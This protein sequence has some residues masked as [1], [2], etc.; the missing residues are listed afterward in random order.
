MAIV[1]WPSWPSISQPFN[2]VSKPS[3]KARLF[4]IAFIAVN[5][6][7]HIF[8]GS[9]TDHGSRRNGGLFECLGIP[10]DSFS[11]SARLENA[12][13]RN[14]DGFPAFDGF[15]DFLDDKGGVRPE[16]SGADASDLLFD[17]VN[18]LVFYHVMPFAV[19]RRE[20]GEFV[21]GALFCGAKCARRA[22][23]IA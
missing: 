4:V 9:E 2:Y 22:R 5:D 7:G 19:N 12:E 15:R 17:I 8:A 20:C 16:F 13:I 23:A 1:V 10:S 11:F 21:G 14:L 3:D 18:Q 6:C